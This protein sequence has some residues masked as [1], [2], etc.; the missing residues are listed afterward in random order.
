[1]SLEVVRW[2]EIS[3]RKTN[4]PHHLQIESKE[5]NIEH[6][7]EMVVARGWM[8]EEMGGQRIQI[9]S[10]KMGKLWG[11]NISYCDYG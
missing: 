4:T 8:V 10:S 1:M 3:Q 11:F 6:N 5:K 7:T 9:S 2:S